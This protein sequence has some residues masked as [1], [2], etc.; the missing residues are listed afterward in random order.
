VVGLIRACVSGIAS[1][2]GNAEGEREMVLMHRGCARV[3][4]RRKILAAV[5]HGSRMD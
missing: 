4:Q 3:L 1:A 2:R 5:H